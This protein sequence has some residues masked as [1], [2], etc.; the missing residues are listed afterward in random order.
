MNKLTMLSLKAVRWSG[1]L[2]MPLTFGFLFT[3]YAISGRY[4]L[5]RYFQEQ[6]AL[7]YHKLLHAPLITLLLVHVVPATYLAMVRW[8]WIKQR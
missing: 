8:G 4:G 7:A 3:G 5:G 6:E 1:W 2:L